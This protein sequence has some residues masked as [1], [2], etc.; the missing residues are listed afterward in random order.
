MRSDRKPSSPQTKKGKIKLVGLVTYWCK[1]AHFY[2][3]N[4]FRNLKQI[5]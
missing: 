4:A 3:L 2:N 1:G 5:P